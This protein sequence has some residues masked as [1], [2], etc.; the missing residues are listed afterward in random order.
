MAVPH[1]WLL[2]ALV[3]VPRTSRAQHA[4]RAE[5]RVDIGSANR[6]VRQDVSQRCHG[7]SQPLDPERPD[8]A[9]MLAL[10]DGFVT[11]RQTWS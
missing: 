4:C 1:E 6:D 2:I 8:I 9:R 10:S 7:R 3:F 11:S 5:L